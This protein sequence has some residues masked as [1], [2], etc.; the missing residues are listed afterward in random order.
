MQVLAYCNC[1]DGDGC[2]NPYANR[3]VIATYE[4]DNEEAFQ[5]DV[6]QEDGGRELWWA[7][8]GHEDVVGG[9]F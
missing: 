9:S 6:D 5:D 4:E 7:G 3:H 2:C 1:S 8:E